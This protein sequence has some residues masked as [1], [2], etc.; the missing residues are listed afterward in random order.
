MPAL[1]TIL[2][3]RAE[4]RAAYAHVRAS[5]KTA[6]PSDMEI[7]RALARDV[8]TLTTAYMRAHTH[9]M[10]DEFERCERR[11]QEYVDTGALGSGDIPVPSA[12][13]APAVAAR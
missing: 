8:S 12:C 13:R 3:K 5:R 2:V 11:L 1:A 7:A 4:M 10:V 9:G 6:M